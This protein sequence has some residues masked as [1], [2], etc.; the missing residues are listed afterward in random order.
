MRQSFLTNCEGRAGIGRAVEL[1]RAGEPALDAAEAAIRLVEDDPQVR[2]VGTGA[3]PDILGRVTCDAA[4]MDGTTRAAGAV[5]CLSG[6]RHAVSVA[7]AVMEKLPHVFLVGAGADRFA[8]EI[9]AERARLLTP[10][11]KER[12][13]QWLERRIPGATPAKLERGPLIDAAWLSTRKAGGTVIALAR[14]RRGNIAAATSTA[15]WACRYPGR[16]GDSPVIGAGLYADSRYGACGCTHVG[17]MT[18]RAATARSVVLYM[19]FGASVEQAVR[20]A[21]RDLHELRG[22]FRGAVMVH[23]MDRAGRA[24]AASTR[25]VRHNLRDWSWQSPAKESSSFIAPVLR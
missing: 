12:Y 1:L 20:E 9:G 10:K 19:K 21:V 4:V 13:R 15:G 18:I 14:D 2:S 22:G 11:A 25:D 23:A 24:F 6:F 17:E 7:R 8:R 3:R 16:L 5:G